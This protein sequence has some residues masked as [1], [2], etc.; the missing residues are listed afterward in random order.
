MFP[1]PINSLTVMNNACF[2]NTDV[3]IAQSD[4]MT[5]LSGSRYLSADSNFYQKQHMCPTTTKNS[6]F[7]IKIESLLA[8]NL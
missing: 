8:L 5:G 2:I 3:P 6:L 7:P 1:E 4:E